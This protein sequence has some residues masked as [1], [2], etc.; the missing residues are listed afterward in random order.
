MDQMQ[1]GTVDFIHTYII[2]TQR[3]RPLIVK[4]EVTVKNYSS[5]LDTQFVPPL[6]V[7]NQMKLINSYCQ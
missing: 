5:V 7:E 4:H 6:E 1:I 2:L 3:Y